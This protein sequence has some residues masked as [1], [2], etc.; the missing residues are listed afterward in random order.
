MARF[1]MFTMMSI[2]PMALWEV[3]M[4]M[5]TCL[6]GFVPD[7]VNLF[8]TNEILVLNSSLECPLIPTTVNYTKLDSSVL[9]TLNDN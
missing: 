1:Q 6:T 8:M 4:M 7:I 2:R 3:F 5:K 9:L